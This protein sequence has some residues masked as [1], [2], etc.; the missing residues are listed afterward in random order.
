MVRFHGRETFFSALREDVIEEEINYYTRDGDVHP[1]RPGPA[2]DFLM[3]VEALP[4]RPTQ[5]DDRQRHDGYRADQMGEQQG[6]IDR[7]K[8]SWL[9]KGCVCAAINPLHARMIDHVTRQEKERS[10]TGGD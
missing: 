5:R 9:Q 7:A 6:Q 10:A 1:D 8:P 3:K 4:K 2:R